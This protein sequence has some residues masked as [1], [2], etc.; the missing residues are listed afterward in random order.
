MSCFVEQVDHAI[1][2]PLKSSPRLMSRDMKGDSITSSIQHTYVH[3]TYISL[4][5]LRSTII[6]QSLGRRWTVFTA[7]KHLATAMLWSWRD[8]YFVS[9]G[10]NSFVFLCPFVFSN[11]TTILVVRNYLSYHLVHMY[12]ILDVRTCMIKCYEQVCV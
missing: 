3:Y 7:V 10:V 11:Q 1:C 6:C 12:G 5:F 2:T 9:L 4:P 8:A